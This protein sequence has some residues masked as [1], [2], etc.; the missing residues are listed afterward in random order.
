MLWAQRG[1]RP[2]AEEKKNITE[3]EIAPIIA[4]GGGASPPPPLLREMKPSARGHGLTKPV[5]KSVLIPI[6][7]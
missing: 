6:R 1:W 7:G 3:I 2:V 4:E 5:L